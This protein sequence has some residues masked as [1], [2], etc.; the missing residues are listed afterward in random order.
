MC[1]DV[2]VSID[3]TCYSVRLVN[4]QVLALDTS[5]IGMHSN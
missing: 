2:E 5:I 1:L 3:I 4:L